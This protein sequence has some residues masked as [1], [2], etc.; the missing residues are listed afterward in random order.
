MHTATRPSFDAW[1]TMF[2]RL[3]L[4]DARSLWSR[5]QGNAMARGAM[6]HARQWSMRSDE[7]PVKIRAA[8]RIVAVP[9]IQPLSY[10]MP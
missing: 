8:N 9:T 3:D 2:I 6:H 10:L 5:Q 4:M 7:F 1:G